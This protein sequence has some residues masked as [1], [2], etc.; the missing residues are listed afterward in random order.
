MRD[1]IAAPKHVTFRS[2]RPANRSAVP[3]HACPD[4]KSCPRHIA[5]ADGGQRAG[6]IGTRDFPHIRGERV[7]RRPD[8]V[9]H[10]KI[11]SSLKA[12]SPF[13]S[14]RTD[15][16]RPTTSDQSA[17]SRASR[18]PGR[19]SRTKWVVPRDSFDMSPVRTCPA[20]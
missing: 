9:P 4:R 13:D 15:D 19:T 1:S 7:V 2:R 11:P 12:I 8:R 18:T 6:W 3:D 5:G 17:F 16:V 14:D 10:P 20:L